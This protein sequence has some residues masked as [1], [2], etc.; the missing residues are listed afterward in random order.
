[1]PRARAAPG[2]RGRTRRPRSRSPPPCPRGPR[3]GGDGRPGLSPR[4]ASPSAGGPPSRR[5]G[6]A[7][8]A[9][10][11]GGDRRSE[12]KDA[13][14]GNDATKEKDATKRI[15]ARTLELP[16][17]PPGRGV[18]HPETLRPRR[19][20]RDPQSPRRRIPRDP[21]GRGPPSSRLPEGLPL[22]P[23]GR[24]PVPR[25]PACPF[26]GLSFSV[27]GGPTVE[28]ARRA[29]RASRGTASA[30]SRCRPSA[31][32]ARRRSAR[33]RTSGSPASGC[34]SAARARARAGEEGGGARER[35]ARRARR[36]EGRG[37]RGRRRRGAGRPLGRRVPARRLADGQ[38][39]ADEHERQRGARQPRER[40]PRRRA[41]RGGGSSTRT[42]T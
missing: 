3:A 27:P 42:T 29:A 12:G 30:R 31:C 32:G 5:P 20:S 4:R 2:R 34:R 14:R 24:P 37:H 26:R 39:H 16:T 8:S 1:M 33:S 7:L 21:S 38:R 6:G 17:V 41:R 36:R 25:G 15:A 18:R 11:G 23:Q 10:V 13:G 22:V 35:R 19:A 40:D 9:P 28:E